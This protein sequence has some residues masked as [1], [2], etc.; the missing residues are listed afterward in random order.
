MVLEHTETNHLTMQAWVA[1][2]G[3]SL[4]AGEG[5]FGDQAYD[6]RK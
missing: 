1:V 6:D 3:N 2:Q 4:V 5:K